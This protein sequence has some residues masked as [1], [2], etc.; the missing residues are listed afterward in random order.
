MI[1]NSRARLTSKERKQ[2]IIISVLPLFAEKGFKATTTKEIAKYANVSEALL[3]KHFSRK[4]EI[5]ESIMECVCE[6]S[7]AIAEILFDQ[8][9]SIDLIINMMFFLYYA[10]VAGERMQGEKHNHLSRLLCFSNLH[11]DGF[12]KR[13]FE[14]NFKPYIPF[15][16]NSYKELVS[17]KIIKEPMLIPCELGGW[18]SHFL[19][20]Q[21]QQNKVNQFVELSYSVDDLVKYGTIYALKAS[22]LS[23]QQ[24]EQNFKYELLKD[25]TENIFKKLYGV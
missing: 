16:E 3:Y 8:E 11:C 19:A 18:F 1:K 23:N 22:G 24:I 7:N 14:K 10:L 17:K 2:A 25:K 9:A 6:E 4:E 21:I 12:S 5:Y 15:F 13:F 20:F